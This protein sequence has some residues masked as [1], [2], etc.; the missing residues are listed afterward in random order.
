MGLRVV[1]PTV[2]P[3]TLLV[4]VLGAGGDYVTTQAYVYSSDPDGCLQY[5]ADGVPCATDHGIEV[6]LRAQNVCVR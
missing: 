5:Q 4:Q 1:A 2:P 3:V 6:R